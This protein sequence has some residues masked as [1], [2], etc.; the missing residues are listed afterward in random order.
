M[1]S[2]P[3]AGAKLHSVLPLAYDSTM[4]LRPQPTIGRASIARAWP[5]MVADAVAVLAFAGVGRRQH[6]EAGALLGVLYTA[7]PFLAGAAITWLVAR[8]WRHPLTLRSGALVGAG[9]W[10]IGMALRALSGRGIAPSFMLVA[11]IALAVLLLGWRA[12][13]SFTRRGAS[14]RPQ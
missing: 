2:R 14:A 7:W 5:A 8:L 9:A 11:A 1:L 3:P 12:V 10:A 6:D 13:V 4:T